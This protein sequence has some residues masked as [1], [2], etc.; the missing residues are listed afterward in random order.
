MLDL[1][2]VHHQAA[3]QDPRRVALHRRAQGDCERVPEQEQVQP[4]RVH[5]PQQ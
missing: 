1:G 5:Q 4:L 2:A 3:R